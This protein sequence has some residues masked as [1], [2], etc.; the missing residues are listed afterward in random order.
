MHT[1]GMTLG[2]RFGFS[3]LEVLKT[4]N[5]TSLARSNSAQNN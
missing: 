4:N 1:V 2:S 3:G 5:F